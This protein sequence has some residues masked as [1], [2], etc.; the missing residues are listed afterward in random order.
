MRNHE[1]LTAAERAALRLL[2]VYTAGRFDIY[3]L[4]GNS[5]AS[6]RAHIMS[7]LEGCRVPQSRAGVTALTAK[8]YAIAGVGPDCHARQDDA[9]IEWCKALPGCPECGVS[10]PDALIAA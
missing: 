5:K 4:A 8:F 10:H 3:V 1:T 6:C 9:F 7:E 2:R